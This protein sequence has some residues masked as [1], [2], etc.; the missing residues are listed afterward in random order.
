MNKPLQ[1][2]QTKSTVSEI[3]EGDFTNTSR[4]LLPFKKAIAKYKARKQFNR[5]KQALNEVEMI[6]AGK[7]KA[8]SIDEFLDEL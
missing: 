4:H 8:K 6:R 3:V 5:I 2:P 7:I 1:I